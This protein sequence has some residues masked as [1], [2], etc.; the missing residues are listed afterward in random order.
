MRLLLPANDEAMVF[1]N[2]LILDNVTYRRVDEI[3]K[4]RDHFLH[5]QNGAILLNPLSVR[6]S[7][8][9]ERGGPA[10][11]Q[12][13]LL[14]PPQTLE[15]SRPPQTLEASRPPQTL[16]VLPRPP[17]TLEVLPRPPKFTKLKERCRQATP[18][19]RSVVF[20]ATN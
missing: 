8:I 2:P 1:L 18:N 16:E 19:P 11:T 14:R 13:A 9:H 3:K 12:E 20:E 10:Q 4:N 15:A 17:Q 5:I 7:D 6:T